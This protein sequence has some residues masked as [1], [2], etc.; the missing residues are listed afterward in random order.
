MPCLRDISDFWKEGRIT[1]QVDDTDLLSVYINNR[2]WSDDG[3][4]GFLAPVLKGQKADNVCR[5]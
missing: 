5:W 3:I 2:S 1:V 4:E